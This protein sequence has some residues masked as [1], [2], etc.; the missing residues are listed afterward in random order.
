MCLKITEQIQIVK[1]C[2]YS[3]LSAFISLHDPKQLCQKKKKPNEKKNKATPQKRNK[4]LWR[5]LHPIQREVQNI[6]CSVSLQKPGLILSSDYR[7]S[8]D[9]Q[10]NA[11]T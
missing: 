6:K 9:D 10:F 1:V 3:S 7:G 5:V 8:L 11:D 4:N 2:S